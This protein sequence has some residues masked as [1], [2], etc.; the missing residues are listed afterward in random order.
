[1]NVT[2][3]ATLT[4]RFRSGSGTLTSR[5]LRFP[6]LARFLSYN[7]MIEATVAAFDPAAQNVLAHV[8]PTVWL[9]HRSVGEH[10]VVVF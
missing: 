10:V 3:L 6:S 8:A 2:F 9:A 5:L 7:R 4:S 1:L